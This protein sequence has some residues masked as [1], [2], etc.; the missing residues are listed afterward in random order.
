MILKE[1][2]KLLNVGIIH[3]ISYAKW[4]SL[5]HVVPKKKGIKILKNENNEFILTRTIMGWCTCIEYSKS[6]KAAR[7]DSFSLPFIDQIVERLTKNSYFYYLDGYLGFFQILFHPAIK[8]MT[9]FTYPYGR[10]AY[11][12]C[13]L[14]YEMPQ[15]PLGDA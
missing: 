13:P 11:K 15:L 12:R 3:P 4:V 2:L 9:T 14:G 7:E 6:I 5:I 10:F 8:K 1:I